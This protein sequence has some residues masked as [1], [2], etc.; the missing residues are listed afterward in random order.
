MSVSVKLSDYDKKTLKELEE[1][2]TFK[3]VDGFGKDLVI[4]GWKTFDDQTLNIPY[5]LGKKLLKV[6]P[7]E[8]NEIKD[9]KKFKFCG[10]LR[11]NQVELKTEAFPR[12]LKYGSVAYYLPCS[13][14]KT[15]L[16]IE[17]ACS[18]IGEIGGNAVITFSLKIL[19]N[20]WE[21]SAKEFSDG[22]IHII[23]KP[24]KINDWKK[25]QEKA[26]F[27]IGMT[28]T[29]KY[30]H[31]KKVD[32]LIL[33]EGHLLCTEN[34]LEKL[35][36]IQ[37]RYIIVLT[38][39]PERDDGME[40]IIV[41]LVGGEKNQ[42][43][44]KSEKPFKVFPLITGYSDKDVADKDDEDEEKSNEKNES[45]GKKEDDKEPDEKEEVVD[46]NVKP[47]KKKTWYER[48]Q[49]LRKAQKSGDTRVNLESRIAAFQERNDKAIL[50]VRKLVHKTSF[51]IAVV[52]DRVA[53][54]EYIQNE[55]DEKGVDVSGLYGKLKNAEN[56]RVLV[57]GIKKCGI[58]FDEKMIKGWDGKR[59]DLMIILIST[60]KMIQTL[61]RALRASQPYIVQLIDKDKKRWF[62][63]TWDEN[64]KIYK[65]MMGEI[66]EECD[67]KSVFE[68]LE[69]EDKYICDR[70]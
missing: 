57:M 50:L 56:A 5:Q 3:Y 6:K 48:Q 67:W 10:Q 69:D 59:I 27:L 70:Q 12:L 32:V 52:G 20:Q 58:G 43:W 8:N 30:L 4:H 18:L 36:E 2:L 41:S 45:N 63:K 33:D 9:Y 62:I 66:Q 40:K 49:D 19:P 23:K 47:K 13:F 46:K 68:R 42:F 55:L 26:N 37:P 60:Y 15:I 31:D 35:L 54:L 1:L 51:K 34:H 22:N 21:E 39:T 14:G 28:S 61:G 7:W 53:Q 16:A 25:E 17:T 65:E 24:T 11:Q 44:R 38:A 29:L 64:V